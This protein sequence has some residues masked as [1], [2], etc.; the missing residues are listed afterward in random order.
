[1][2]LT[3]R[4]K[5]LVTRLFQRMDRRLAPHIGT[6][7]A[8]TVLAVMQ[9]FRDVVRSVDPA[10]AEQLVAECCER[11]AQEKGNG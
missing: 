2:S 9:E 4:E 8:G 3:A 1:M 11:V 6:L 10:L 7:H 5:D